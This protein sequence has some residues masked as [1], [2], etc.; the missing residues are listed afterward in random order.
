MRLTEFSIHFM[1]NKK[2]QP[3]INERSEPTEVINK[4]SVDIINNDTA[5]VAR[6]LT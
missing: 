1:T 3:K 4:I 2:N 6:S 5:N